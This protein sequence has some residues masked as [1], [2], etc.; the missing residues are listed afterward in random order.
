MWTASSVPFSVWRKIAMATWQ[1]R[2]DSIIWATMDIDAVRLL[3]YIDDVR[4]ATGQHVTPMDLV[5]RASAKVFEALPGLNGRV[6]FGNFVASSTIDAFFVVSLRTDPVAGAQASSTDLSGTVVRRVDEKTPWAIAKEI[7]DRASRI[8]HDADPQFKQAKAVAKAL[9]P[10]LLG[11]V[12]DAIAFVTE[13]LQLPL[14][15]LGMEARPYG[16]ILISNVGTYGLDTAAAPW[17]TFCHVPIGIMMGAVADKV[18]ARG[19]QPVVR[20][21]LPLTIG[22]DHRF[23]DGYQAATMS[24]V[25][26]EYLAEPAV[27]DPVPTAPSK[28]AASV[29]SNGKKPTTAR[30]RKPV[31]PQP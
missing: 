13:S 19:G 15:L 2:K 9:P 4:A 31:S 11:P 29:R 18:V 23:V 27:F 26:R 3:E 16:S 20:P 24:R 22:L 30:T 21:V 25:F 14:P 8:R 7:A 12:M 10:V 1:P 28:S 17:P 5:G 6:V